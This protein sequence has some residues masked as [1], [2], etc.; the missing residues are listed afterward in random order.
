M[1]NIYVSS[2][3]S[4]TA[5]Y[6]TWVKAATTLATGVGAATA[7]DTIYVINTHTETL[8]ADTTY[9]FP[10]TSGLR[11]LCVTDAAEPPTTLA[12]LLGVVAVITGGA[13]HD[14]NFTGKAYVHGIEFVTTTAT[15]AS[16]TFGST[17]VPQAL[18]FNACYFHNA[19]THASSSIFIG[20]GA[21]N[22]NDDCE[23]ILTNCQ[24]SFANTGQELSVR[25]GRIRIRNLVLASGSAPVTLFLPSSSLI[26]DIIVESSDLSGL[27]WSNLVSLTPAATGTILFRNCL[28]NAA[29]LLSTG[30]IPGAGGLKLVVD[31]CTA[32]DGTY[33]HKHTKDYKGS[34]FT[35]T[36]IVRTDGANDGVMSFSWMAQ[37]TANTLFSGANYECPEIVRWN[38]TV[39]SPITVEVEV[40]H[41]S[42]GS[43][44]ASAL[45]DKEAWLEVQYLGTS[46]FSI[47]SMINDA[48]SPLSAGTD[49]ASSTAAWTTTGLATP[50]KQ[51]LSVTFTP[52]IEGY[53]HAVVHLAGVSDTVYIC[54]KLTVS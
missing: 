54:P 41:D 4:N 16:I 43:G 18:Y 44:T 29:G 31:N 23:L 3:G 8:G 24:A 40:V 1:A 6:E 52:E 21:S 17:N 20:P 27:A 53:I 50:V 33:Y 7:A 14:I 32:S 15:L 46:G 47:G 26:H 42:V 2:A 11:I 5:P 38:E 35:E 12:S 19:C 10:S 34:I 37:T 25:H 30:T 13:G 36:T 22:L 51:K 48:G 9:T 49:Q 28:F 45:T 39:G